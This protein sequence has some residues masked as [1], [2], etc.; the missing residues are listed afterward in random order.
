MKLFRLCLAI[1]V[2]TSLAGLAYVAQQ[3]ENSGAAMVVAAENFLG[4]LK[5]EQKAQATFPYDS[6]ER[7][8]WYFTPQQDKAKKATRKGLPLEDM[9]AEQKKTALALLKAGTSPSGNVAANTIMSLEAILRDQENGAMVRNPEWYFFTIFGTPAKTGKWGWRVEG[10]HLSLNFTMDGTQVVA[11]T[12]FFFGANPAEVK[13]G[14]RKGLRI[15]APAEDLA[16][17][18]YNALTDEQKKIALQEIK[19]FP[20]PG[21]K[22]LTPKVGAPVGLAATK[23]SNEQKKLLGKLLQSYFE[24]MPADVGA[25]ELADAKDAGLDK[26]HF[27]LTGSTEPG[28]GLT[29]R[30]QGPTFVIEFLNMQSDS[31]G[32][33]ANHI[34]SATRRIKGDFGLNS[35]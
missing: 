33:R 29:Y 23:M 9:T 24:R 13:S 32:N 34:H 2:L 27:A 10:H 20:E 26:V 18:L 28:K 31:A 3:T 16:K 12:P 6:G 8:N 5:P 25:R 4:G 21:E 15:L 22:T 14:D 17:D 1:A 30:V 7:T 11:A 35:N 19:Q